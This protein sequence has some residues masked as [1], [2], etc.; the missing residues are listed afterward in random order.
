MDY[1]TSGVDIHKADDLIADVGAAAKATYSKEV[2]SGVGGFGAL[3]DLGCMGM[4]HPVLVSATDGVGTKILIANAMQKYD[5]LGFDLVAMNCDDVICMGAKPLFFLDYI[6]LG[7]LEEKQYMDLIRSIADGCKQAGISLIGG[8]TAELPGMYRVGEY[9]LAGF[10]VGAADKD[11]MI[12]SERVKEGDV[13]FGLMSSGFHSNGYS[14]VRK[15]VEVKGLELNKDYGFGK[16]GDALLTP[17]RIYC[18]MLWDALRELK[19]SIRGM[20]HI[21]GGGIPGNLNRVLPKHLDAT[22]DRESWKLPEMMRF[23]VEQ[24]EI[25]RE[26]SYRVFNMGIGMAVIVAK[27]EAEAFE[28]FTKTKG[29]DTA[30]IGEITGGKGQVVWK[31]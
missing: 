12:L 10:C 11:E 22:V 19:R 13:V 3:F 29:F 31:K 30:R 1:K 23:I 17:T 14:L 27:G 2:M 28:Q 24:G 18:S 4:K 21:T 9:D 5:T 7:K 20:A 6:A 16:L 25:E 15:V 26:E 8:E